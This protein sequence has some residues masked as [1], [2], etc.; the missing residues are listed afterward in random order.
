MGCI[1]PQK[2]EKLKGLSPNLSEG[3]EGRIDT[4]VKTARI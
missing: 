1:N 2:L 3:N 4:S